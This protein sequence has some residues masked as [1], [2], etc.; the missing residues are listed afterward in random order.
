M[1]AK[2]VSR[3]LGWILMGLVMVGLVGFGAT[4][5]G[6]SAGAVA[7][8]GDTDVDANRYFRELNAEFRAFEAQTNQRVTMAQA[9]LFGLDTQALGRLI[10]T[11]TLEN[12]TARL[13]LS[14]GDEAVRDQ[15]VL[16]DA[17]KA[18]DGSF[19]RQAY[20]FALQQTGLTAKEYEGELRAETARSILQMAVQ[21][22]VVPQPVYT[23]T[24]YAHAR[25]ARSFT[26]AALGLEKLEAEVAAPTDDQLAAWYEANQNA[27]QLPEIKHLTYAWLD[28]ETIIPTVEVTEA[29]LRALYDSRVEEYRQPERRLVE[30]LVFPTTEDAQSAADRL[31]AGEVTF[32]ALVAERGLEL[33]DVDMGDVTR[34]AL[35]AAGDAVFALVDD[36]AV[37]API[38]SGLGPALFRMNTILAEQITTFEDAREALQGEFAADTARRQIEALVPELDDLMAGGATLEELAA[39]HGLTLGTLDWTQG[40][41][42]GIAAY[43]SFREAAAA[44]QSSDFPEIVLMS[45]GGLFALRADS[46]DAPRVQALDEARDIAV[47]GWTRG[48]ALRLL[49]LQGEALLKDFAAGE[50]PASK[51]LI[52]V[53]EEGLARTDSIEGAP[54]SLI[55]AVFEMETG[56]WRVVPAAEGVA[57][58]RLDAVTPADQNSDDALLVKEQFNLQLAQEL[59][60]D[61][62]LAFTRALQADAGI[63]L[64]RAVIDAVNAQFP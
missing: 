36:G 12:E 40:S 5:F 4:N 45:D 15:V 44:V 31:A 60:I 64:N 28:P 42:E 1:A 57:L 16:I 38:D 39:D 11:V 63:T 61:L 21:T 33:A 26:W 47:E 8:V 35:G 24:L 32:E 37:T 25:E 17:F 7:R 19:D 23:D 51:G 18:P 6:T 3:T 14:V 56:D 58:V 49:T 30:R 41:A 53:T 48:E 59:G 54:Q 52:E 50:S 34:E 55:Q 43:D 9:R 13:G 46:I 27:F 62:E 2:Q 29:D 20:E 10:A 22:G